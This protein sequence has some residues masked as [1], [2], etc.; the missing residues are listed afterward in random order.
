MFKGKEQKQEKNRGIT[1]IALVITIIVMLILV[2]TTITMAI[3]G[4]L[5]ENAWRAVNEMQNAIDFEQQLA[6]G[7]I[8]ANGVWYNSIDEYINGDQAP[9][10]NWT[11]EGDTFTCS[12]CNL[13][14]TMGEVVN[15]TP[16]GEKTSTKITAQM[17]GLDKYYK[18][19]SSYPT[20][21]N[22]D[23]EGNQIIEVQ[24]TEWVVLG[25]EDTDKDG[26]NETLLITTKE[27]VEAAASNTEICLYGAASYNNGPKEINR[28]C[29]ELYSN[30]E[31]G[32]ARGMTVEDVNNALNYTPIGGIYREADGTYKTT[33]N[34]TTK[35]KD[36]PTWNNIKSDGTYT[37]NGINTEEALGEYNL[38]GY[39][40]VLGNDGTLVNQANN[41]T[42][43][44]TETEKVIIFGSSGNYLYWLASRGI[45]TDSYYVNFGP[46]AVF[47]GYVSSCGTFFGSNGFEDRD[48]GKL[49][50][51]VCL[52]SKIP[53]TKGSA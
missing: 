33:E 16:A 13:T 32:K 18:K 47:E 51:V 28:I 19:N 36:L 23:E 5:F 3:N 14:Y 21:V 12:H 45:Y 39:I 15:Y 43:R 1:L 20:D 34:L 52:K 53:E 4:G 50:P 17:S 35:L 11:R 30:S 48:N 9:E 22:V 42:S 31:Y 37:P 44:I 29:E 7:K 10:H 38:N 24:D 40:Y 26:I 41:T 6:D 8:Y 2:T 49:R 25:I 27:P 46:S